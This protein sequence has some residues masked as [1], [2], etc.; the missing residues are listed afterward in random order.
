M[1]RSVEIELRDVEGCRKWFINGRQTHPRLHQEYDILSALGV[2][3][4]KGPV[5]LIAV[6]KGE[7]IEGAVDR[8]ID[9]AAN[10]FSEALTPEGLRELI[11]AAR[12][13]LALGEGR[14]VEV[15]PHRS[16]TILGEREPGSHSWWIIPDA[17]RDYLGGEGTYTFTRHPDPEP[18]FPLVT[19]WKLKTTRWMCPVCNHR[20]PAGSSDCGHCRVRF[21]PEA[22][23]L[24]EV[25]DE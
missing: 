6:P 9:C 24:P 2:L 20:A 8:L 12:A 1:A 4:M 22:A 13:E 10:C 5:T 18:R 25:P 15:F 21:Y 7:K 17:M 14:V 3:S 23:D 19:A 16:D 11:A